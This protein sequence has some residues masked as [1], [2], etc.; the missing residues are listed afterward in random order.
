MKR[1][2]YLYEEICSVE[3]CRAAIMKAS[4]CKRSRSDVRRVLNRID[5]FA[6]E[7]HTILVNEEYVPSVY[8]I[9]DI[10]DGPSHKTRSIQVPRFWPDQCVHHA[11]MNVLV[12][13]IIRGSYRCSCGSFPNRGISAAKKAVEKATLCDKKNAKYCAKLDITK[14]YA[15]IPTDRLKMKFARA[16]KDEKA[17]RLINVIIDSHPGGLP[18]GNYT[19][20]WFANFYLQSLDHYIKAGESAGGLG[21]THYIRYID[22]MVLLGSNKRKLHKDVAAIMAYVQDEL[23]L[24]IKDNWQVFKVRRDKHMR[25]KCD[26]RPVDFLGYCFCIGYTTLRKR[27]ALS[28]MRASR[29]IQR[30]IRYKQPIPFTLAAGFLSRVGQAQ[31]CDYYGLRRA[32]I[33]VI[34]IKK[35]K[36]VVRNESKRRRVA[37]QRIQDRAAA[38]TAGHGLCE[39]V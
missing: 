19:S 9:L 26:G 11:L 8:R 14:F 4:E 27:N 10:T 22:D 34:S 23:G 35:L 20:A 17:L 38:R 37:E 30:L 5:E 2:G 28:L 3:N 33:D 6:N 18:I 1:I 39:A 29:K 25:G 24:K 36:E 13:I 32:Y 31:H 7:L 15:S 16:I 12:P 21:V